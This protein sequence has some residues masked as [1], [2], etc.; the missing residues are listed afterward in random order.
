[1]NKTVVCDVA[2][3]LLALMRRDNFDPL[4]ERDVLKTVLKPFVGAAHESLFQLG[5]KRPQ[6]PDRTR[7]IFYSP[8]LIMFLSRFGTD[9]RLPVHNHDSWNILMI[10]S[11]SMHFR[12]FRRLDDRTDAGQ[13]KL[14][15]ADDRVVT[16][17]EMGIVA[18]PPHDIH[19]LEILTEGTWMLTVAPCPEPDLREIYNP[20]SGT[21]EMKPL[22][23]IPQAA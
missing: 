5:I 6:P 3:D 15:V 12:W 20:S 8:E 4:Q 21:F 9:F 16:A 2:Q 14:E 7:M 1:M 23:V 10:C 22:S 18:P 17:G 11:G 13:A 19:Q